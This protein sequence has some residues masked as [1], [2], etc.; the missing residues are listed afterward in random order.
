MCC[1]LQDVDAVIQWAGSTNFNQHFPRLRADQAVL[2]ISCG[3]VLWYNCS[4]FMFILCLQMKGAV[5][6]A[7]Y[8][9][10]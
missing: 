2:L 9:D 3:E 4:Q 6:T 10:C 8:Y 1:S 7:K 5:V